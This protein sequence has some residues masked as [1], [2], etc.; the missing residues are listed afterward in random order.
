MAADR[1]MTW[2]RVKP[3]RLRMPAS[4]PGRGLPQLDLVAVWVHHPAELAEFGFFDLV[5]HLAALGA[6][7]GDDAMQVFDPVIDHELRL[8]G[9]E[10]VRFRLENAPHGGADRVR[11]ARRFPAEG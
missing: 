6:Q 11:A 7:C 3:L 10:V 2:R 8:A 4:L 9:I 5:H 1:P